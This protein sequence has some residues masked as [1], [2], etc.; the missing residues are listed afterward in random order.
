MKIVSS[1]GLN[2]F[3]INLILGDVR[4]VSDGFGGG[5]VERLLLGGFWG[6]CV[7]RFSLEW[8]I[9]FDFRL[10]FTKGDLERELCVFIWDE[11]YQRKE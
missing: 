4:F 5:F 6:V 10:G 11:L 9:G 1:C 2:L 3:I 7:D 8:K